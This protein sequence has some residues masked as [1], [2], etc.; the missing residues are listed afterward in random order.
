VALSVKNVC[1]ADLELSFHQNM[2]DAG[3]LLALQAELDRRLLPR[4]RE[5]PGRVRQQLAS[6]NRGA[7]PWSVA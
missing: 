6:L 4:A 2:D 3:T 5:L 1:G 7:E